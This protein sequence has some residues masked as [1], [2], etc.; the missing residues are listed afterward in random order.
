MGGFW[1]TISVTERNKKKKSDVKNPFIRE[2][3]VP[4][5]MRAMTLHIHKS[6]FRQCIFIHIFVEY[7][8]REREMLT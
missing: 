7:I 8:K 2:K 4:A 1:T 6:F 3:F 5:G